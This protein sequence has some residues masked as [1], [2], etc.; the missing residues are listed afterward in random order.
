VEE[1]APVG[2]RWLSILARRKFSLLR[3]RFYCPIDHGGELR[4]MIRM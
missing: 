4:N 1:L 3:R 2:Q